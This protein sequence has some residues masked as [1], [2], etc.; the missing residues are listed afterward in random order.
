MWFLGS[1]QVLHSL[2]LELQF[3]LRL[4]LIFAV[5]VSS[6]SAFLFYFQNKCEILSEIGAFLWKIS[7]LLGSFRIFCKNHACWIRELLHMQQVIFWTEVEGIAW[8]ISL[9]HFTSMDILIMFWLLCYVWLSCLFRC[10]LAVELNKQADT[11]P[12]RLWPMEFS[13]CFLRESSQGLR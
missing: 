7:L 9:S 2:Y 1:G 8:N 3:T 5:N 10:T 13:V 4:L 6:D 12:S 11:G